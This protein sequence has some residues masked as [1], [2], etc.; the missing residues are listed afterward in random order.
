MRT[1]MIEQTALAA[2]VDALLD[3]LYTHLALHRDLAEILEQKEQAMRQLEL[4][5]LDAIVEKEQ[6]LIHRIAANEELR[7]A[8]TATLTELLGV[9]DP[10]TL[11]LSAII[12]YVP[13]E[14][15]DVLIEVRDELYAI[16]DRIR[17]V[18]DRNRTLVTASLDHIHIFLSVLSAADG[19]ATAYNAQGALAATARPAV[20][21]RRF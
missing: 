6:A 12:A 20:L 13:P 11:R 4:E 14:V 9:D 15:G 3:T 16:A 7:C 21:D 17:K 8:R 5:D 19:D 10:E 2:Q 18:Q 1:L